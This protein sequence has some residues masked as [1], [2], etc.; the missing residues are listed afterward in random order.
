MDDDQASRIVFESV[1]STTSPLFLTG[2]RHDGDEAKGEQSVRFQPTL[3]TAGTYR[4]SIAYTA[5]ANRATNVPVLIHH[6]DGQ[7]RV[8]VNQKLKPNID[9]VLHPLGTYRFESG[10][11]SY[12][13]ISNKETD[14][15]VI[16]DAVQWLSSEAKP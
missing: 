11:T 5:F 4:V 14:G 7:T 3:P 9:G 6:A 8:I 2:Y 1:G 12:V 13:E 15:H 10:K 16:I